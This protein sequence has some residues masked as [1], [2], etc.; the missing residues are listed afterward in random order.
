MASLAMM[1][2]ELSTGLPRELNSIHA[3]L[4]VEVPG[5]VPATPAVHAG[6]WA[7]VLVAA[8]GHDVMEPNPK[9]SPLEREITGLFVCVQALV[10]PSVCQQAL[11]LFHTSM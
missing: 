7:V 9:V 3:V 4:E 1:L 11:P 8:V 6:A 5:L 2:L 10:S